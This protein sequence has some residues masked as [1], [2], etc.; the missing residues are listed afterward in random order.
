MPT[1]A[2][3]KRDLEE[4][5][6]SG[7]VIR[8]PLKRRQRQSSSMHA[9]PHR[10]NNAPDIVLLSFFDGL[11]SAPLIVQRLCASSNLTWRAIL[12]KDLQKLTA[13]KFPE[14]EQ[15]GDIDHDEPQRLIGR[16][17]EIDPDSKACV[18]IAGGPPCHDHSRIKTNAPGRH[19]Q[20][21]SK[22]VRFAKFV[23]E[24]EASWK[25]AQAILVVENVVPEHKQDIKL[26]EQQLSA[27]AVVCDASDLGVVSRPR[28]WWTRIPWQEVSH[29][30][31]AP[32][33]LKWSTYQGI[34]R[35]TFEACRAG[36][37]QRV[38]HG[39]LGVA[40]CYHRKKASTA[41][42]SD[43][44][45]RGSSGSPSPAQLQGQD[46]F[47]DAVAMAPGQSPVCAVALRG[48]EPLGGCQP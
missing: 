22:F 5:P 29:R 3:R 47:F 37:C 7:G 46:R 32:T 41:A 1:A 36:R 25:Y 6:D 28:V 34:P 35:V 42:M 19:G 48:A 39:C 9:T 33:R 8:P 20:E 12:W 21:G 2:T 4:F 45:V 11:G 16:L 14:A 44:A 17:G 15:R 13:S 43:Y 18:I 31:N 30:C 38:R 26:F 27:Q 40:C 23:K 24:L 10:G